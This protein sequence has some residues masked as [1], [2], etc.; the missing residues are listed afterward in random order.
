MEIAWHPGLSI[1]AFEPFLKAVG[2]EYGWLGG[3][4]NAGNLRCVL[5]YTI[6]RKAIF[7][8]VRFR[9]ETMPMV[10]DFSVEEEKAFL[11]SA[12][13]YFRSTG[14]DM[15]MPATT[16][17]IFRT[18]PDGAIVAPYGSYVIDLREPEDN[19][20]RNVRKTYR[21]NISRAQNDGVCIR[22][23][24][25]ENLDVAY[26]L[27]RD[28]FKRSKL[29]F[30]SHN[31]FKHYVL[32]IADNCKIIVAYYQAIAQS[33]T[34][35]AYSNHCAYAVY[36][37]SIEDIHQG[38]MK[39]IDWEAIRLFKEVGVQQFDFVGARINPEKGSKQE[40]I[41][42][43]KRR[44]GAALKQGYIWKYS[45]RPLKFKLYN[46]ASQ[47]RSGGDIVDAE[48]H[49]HNEVTHSKKTIY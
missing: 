21:Q 12:V 9:V 43:Y 38:A 8:M 35:Y 7:S 2:D 39:L 17:T 46:L 25:E 11:N 48:H 31:E 3:F 42:D 30:M 26:T 27:V 49:K 1:F 44:F 14:A 40:S 47:V 29:P 36:G 13:E 10:E 15:I 4:D 5:P 45:F 33:T 41:N 16:N 34:V 18:Y 23:G 20:W 19:L 32:S 22:N 28:T 6:I 37:G 24:I